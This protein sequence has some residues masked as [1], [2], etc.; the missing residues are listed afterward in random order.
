MITKHKGKC[1]NGYLAK[2]VWVDEG[3][4]ERGKSL[5]STTGKSPAKKKASQN[6]LEQVQPLPLL[7]LNRRC[8]ELSAAGHCVIPACHQ[9]IQNAK[10]N[11]CC[12]THKHGADNQLDWR[13]DD[14]DA[15]SPC[16]HPTRLSSGHTDSDG[17]A[18]R[19]IRLCTREGSALQAQRCSAV[20]Q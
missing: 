18:L 3:C 6:V 19:C 8:P 7:A 11:D 16:N 4:W 1:G 17:A 10:R 12:G 5:T 14:T 13:R 15:Q 9:H 2:C 20:R